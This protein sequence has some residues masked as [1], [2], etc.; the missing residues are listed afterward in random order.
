MVADGM[1]EME[2]IP[3]WVTWH[4]IAEGMNCPPWEMFDNGEP[5][6]AKA[7]W[8]ETRRIYDAGNAQANR[9]IANRKR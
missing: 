4:N 9:E 6:P 5:Q 3:D 1:M 8:R 7:W 2:P